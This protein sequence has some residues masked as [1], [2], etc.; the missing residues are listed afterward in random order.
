MASPAPGARQQ[1][2]QAFWESLADALGSRNMWLYI[3]AFEVA[4]TLLSPFPGE[5]RRPALNLA[6]GVIASAALLAVFA[7][8]WFLVL[9]HLHGAV[10]VLAALP[11]MILAGI[12]RGATLQF[13]L[14]AWD[15]SDLGM[16]GYRWRTL[17]AVL[18][19]LLGVSTGAL[20]KAGV[21]GHRTRL[22]R[23][24]AEQQ[25]LALVLADAQEDVHSDQSGAMAQISATLSAQLGSVRSAAPAAVG[26][27]LDEIATSVVRPLS[28]ELAATAPTWQPPTPQVTRVN[29]DWSRVW[30]SATSVGYIEPL[31]P[32]L[33]VLLF[34]PTSM[35]L[36]GFASGLVMHIAGAVMVYL[37]LWLMRTVAAGVG[38]DLTPAA[39]LVV[40]AVLLA[41]AC[42][43]AAA[44]IWLYPATSPVINAL[45]MITV[46]PLTALLLSFARAARVQRR[47]IEA[48]VGAVVDQTRWWV[49][50]TRMV[51]WWQSG[52]LARA[53][54]GP[55][56]SA[57]HVAA[58][59]VRSAVDAA[60]A[61]PEFVEAALDDVRRTLTD[62]VTRG[63]A[64]GEV[65]DEFSTLAA[66]WHP[67][68]DVQHA[69]TQA[70]A[71]GLA[72]DVVCAEITADVVAEAVSN[73]VRHGG[74]RHIDI[75]VDVRAANVI[76]V[77]VHD[78][79]AGWQSQGAESQPGTGLGESQLQM[80]ALTWRYT[81]APGANVLRVELPLLLPEAVHAAHRVPA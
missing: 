34:A 20:V 36:N 14:T 32:A 19:V 42:V 40:T 1:A 28:H 12:A 50:R 5:V 2:R 53:L 27:V 60:T 3:A 55:V 17:T 81:A 52:T 35:L 76:T 23:L 77:D 31:G 69:V 26:D 49:C 22:E 75:A 64:A 72:A 58:Q 70:A 65:A 9:R 33:F 11:I 71:A 73:A 24:A 37:G 66:T 56:Q 74:A 51:W 21:E 4:V 8:G 30:G 45:Y 54:H 80:C 57:I 68:V 46:V 7:V 63:D 13:V 25:Q 6:A 62:V 78:D 18:V 61:T 47:Q 38:A 43:P 15:M 16:A 48:A 41:L 44:L 29:V 67:L 10:R 59:R 39:R 79:G